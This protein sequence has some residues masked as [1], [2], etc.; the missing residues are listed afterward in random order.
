[1]FN[2]A[3]ILLLFQPMPVE[4]TV[5]TFNVRYDNPDDGESA[6]AHRI[7]WVADEMSKADLIGVQEAL[8]HQVQQ[9][10][11]V[12]DGYEWVGVGRDDGEQQGEFA[13][14]FYKTSVFEPLEVKTIWLSDFPDQPG[15]VGWDAALPRIATLVTLKIRK[16]GKVIQV[17][18]THFDHRGV[19]ARLKSAKLITDH[20]QKMDQPVI[21]LGDFNAT[22]ES[23]VYSILTEQDLRDARIITQKP[24]EGPLG[25]FSGFI[26]RDQLDESPRIDYVF[27][28]D[29]F[30]VLS[31][32]AVISVKNGRYV[33][34]HLPV[35]VDIQ[36]ME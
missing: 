15:S 36:I 17:I 28:S 33:S 29:H 5:M 19:D 12:L 8:S 23:D 30:A 6:W 24:A 10:A 32:E 9:L 4:F 35:K 31:Y 2:F 14:I 20:L 26:Q 11:V 22:P 21:L 18:N 16:T 1:M 27:V 25:T 13:P 34:D 3:L 7:S